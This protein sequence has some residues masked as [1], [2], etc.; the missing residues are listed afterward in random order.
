MYIYTYTIIQVC[1]TNKH[2]IMIQ[3]ALPA[4][5]IT[6]LWQIVHWWDTRCTVTHCRIALWSHIKDFQK[7]CSIRKHRA[8]HYL[9]TSSE[10]CHCSVS[11]WRH[12]QSC[13]KT[14]RKHCLYIAASSI[15]TY[16]HIL[17]ITLKYN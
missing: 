9:N 12:F 10:D 1:L 17:Y 14:E 5:T 8:E 13:F 4:I 11:I 15:R 3:C 7:E 6:A 2:E 16:L